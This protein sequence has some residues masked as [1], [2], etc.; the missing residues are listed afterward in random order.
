MLKRRRK[1]LKSLIN[2]LKD[3]K[4]YVEESTNQ[5]R[6]SLIDG[7]K[8][9]IIDSHFSIFPSSYKMEYLKEKMKTITDKDIIDAF[10]YCCGDER[11]D[12]ECNP[13]KCYLYDLPEER[14]GECRFCRQWL[15]KDGLE[16]ILRLMKKVGGES[17][18]NS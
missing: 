1:P 13:E 6:V 8:N 10:R 4:V 14:N 15:M 9:M 2:I 11:T 3:N 7:N 18:G 16:L 12:D 5:D 17:N